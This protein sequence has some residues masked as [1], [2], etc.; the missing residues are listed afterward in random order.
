MLKLNFSGENAMH[1]IKT[2]LLALTL[3]CLSLGANAQEAYLVGSAGQ[4]RW[5]YACGTAGCERSTAAWRV[6]AGYR[7]NRAVAL[8]GFYFDLG[9]ARSSDFLLD[10]RLGAT[11]AGVQALFGWPIGDVELAGKIGVASMHNDFRAS[12]TSLTASTRVHRTEAIG[13]LVSSYRF[14]PN[15]S[16]RLD[17]DVVTVALDGDALFYSRGSDVTGVMLGLVFRF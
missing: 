4:S 14:T 3:Q 1:L 6:A 12:A 2:G 7:F 5:A 8:E 17:V 9:R 10:G 13:G 15:L 11:G 16:L